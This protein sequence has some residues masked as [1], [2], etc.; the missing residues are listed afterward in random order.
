MRTEAWPPGGARVSEELAPAVPAQT[1]LQW[2][3]RTRSGAGLRSPWSAWH[4]FSLPVERPEVAPVRVGA[5]ASITGRRLRAEVTVPRDA[6]EISSFEVQL[7]PRSRPDSPAW[8]TPLWSRTGGPSTPETRLMG[9]SRTIPRT[10]GFWFETL[11]GCPKEDDMLVGADRPVVRIGSAKR[12]RSYTWS[13]HQFGAPVRHGK[14]ERAT[15]GLSDDGLCLVFRLPRLVRR[16]TLPRGFFFPPFDKER[17]T[18]RGETYGP[19]VVPDSPDGHSG[20]AVDFNQGSHDDDAGHP[21]LAA[22]GGRVT[23]VRDLD[24]TVQIRHWGGAYMTEYT[25]MKQIRGPTV[26]RGPR[27]R[28]GGRAPEDRGDREG[29]RQGPASPSPPLPPDRERRLPARQDAISAASPA[30]RAS[31]AHVGQQEVGDRIRNPRL[32]SGPRRGAHRQGPLGGWDGLAAPPPALRR[33]E[34]CVRPSHHAPT[35]AVVRRTR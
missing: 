13:L 26:Q 10:G 32:G 4:G 25:H 12:I 33:G 20:F 3:I 23:M 5:V 17:L 29:G 34:V 7:A 9:M 1:A 27:P 14:G 6:R 16:G 30:S 28:N 24:G 35:R 2:R 15:D 31:R 22:A 19:N 11:D 18:Y 21:V 8:E